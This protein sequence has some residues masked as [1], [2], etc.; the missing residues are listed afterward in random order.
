[1]LKSPANPYIG[2]IMRNRTSRFYALSLGVGAMLTILNTFS[3]ARAQDLTFQQ[4]TY[5]EGR[6]PEC[7]VAADV[8]GDGAPDLIWANSLDNTFFVLTNNYNNSGSFFLMAQLWVGNGP[9][10]VAAA[11]VNGDGNPDLITAN[12]GDNTLTVL[13]NNG[14]GFGLNATLNVGT[15][16][17]CVVAADVN[18]DGK[19][20]LITAN[21]IFQGTLTVLTNNGHGVF[22]SNATVQVGS[23]PRC[24]VAADVN[25]DGKPDLITANE[26]DDTLTV[27]TN[28]G[29][30]VFGSNNTLHV[31]S[32]PLQLIAV[33]LNRD[34]KMD[35]A[36]GLKGGYPTYS[37]GLVLFTNN[38]SGVLVSNAMLNTGAP[39]VCAA[40]ADLNSDGHVDLIAA[41]GGSANTLT[42]F[43]NNGSGVFSSNMTIIMAPEW[44]GY[45]GAADFTGDGKADLFTASY[46]NNSVTLLVNTT[47]FLPRLNL[48]SSGNQ[49]KLNWQSWATN[50]VLEATTNLT[51]SNWTPVTNPAP[52]GSSITLTNIGPAQFFR[53]KSQ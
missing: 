26:S 40:A 24:V 21:H 39:A 31:G 34:G 16:P 22:G 17:V 32:D 18:G 30:G 33:D 37:G 29:T 3:T 20:D 35:L 47:P 10:F 2:A 1:M 50:Y 15:N 6:G 49:L 52:V 45:V 53:L 51:A 19:P 28:N 46:H 25:G 43:T 5:Y 11:D 38:G 14:T 27:M 44:P 13:T 42:I 36:C 8:N 7:V 48:A 41:N 4:T 23:Y 12:S 9:A